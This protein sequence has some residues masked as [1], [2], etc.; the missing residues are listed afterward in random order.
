MKAFA[1]TSRGAFDNQGFGRGFAANREIEVVVRSE[2]VRRDFDDAPIGAF[3]QIES[4]KLNDFRLARIQAYLVLFDR[5]IVDLQIN[6]Q[7]IARRI[8]VI[9]DL[10]RQVLEIF[11]TEDD[12]VRIDAGHCDIGGRKY[13]RSE[14][15]TSELQ[16]LTNLVCRLLLEK[17]KH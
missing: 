15:H 16:S 9:T 10:N 6:R 12:T 2:V 4:G 3:S 1:A 13:L 11:L 5:L 17:K 7:P 8:A 14:E